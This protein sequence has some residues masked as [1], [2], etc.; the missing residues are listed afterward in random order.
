M[1]K[2]VIKLKD[3]HKHLPTNVKLTL[4]SGGLVTYQRVLP[5]E[6]WPKILF[7]GERVFEDAGFYSEEK[8]RVYREVLDTCVALDNTVISKL[9]PFDR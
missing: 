1:S 4:W 3:R 9:I 5:Y 7:W 2:K 8:M 6:I